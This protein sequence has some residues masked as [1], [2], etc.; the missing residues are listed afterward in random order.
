MPYV[1][2]SIYAQHVTVRCLCIKHINVFL[3]VEWKIKAVFVSA[4][5]LLPHCNFAKHLNFE[6]RST[7]MWRCDCTKFNMDDKEDRSVSQCL[8]VMPNQSFLLPWLMLEVQL[9]V[10][11]NWLAISYLSYSSFHLVGLYYVRP[12]P[13]VRACYTVCGSTEIVAS[14]TA[15]ILISCACH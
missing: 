4:C 15:D 12:W 2:E 7:K 3:H 13:C 11:A 8:H 5:S 9:Y 1:T 14:C 6:E 10:I